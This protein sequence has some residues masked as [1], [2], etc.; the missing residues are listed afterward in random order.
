MG[1]IGAIYHLA[2]IGYDTATG[3]HEKIDKYVEK[4]KRILVG[5]SISP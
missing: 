1:I 2:A 3:Q 5:A 4:I